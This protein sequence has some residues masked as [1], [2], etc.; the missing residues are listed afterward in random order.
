MKDGNEKT[1][2]Q[3]N[4]SKFPEKVKRKKKKKRKKKNQEQ[5]EVNYFLH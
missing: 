3:E 2:P 4:V 5:I 1:E